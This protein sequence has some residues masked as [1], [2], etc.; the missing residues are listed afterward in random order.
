[1]NF[2][3]WTI[4]FRFKGILNLAAGPP[5]F[6]STEFR[7]GTLFDLSA[8]GPQPYPNFLFSLYDFIGNKTP[9]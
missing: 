8:P 3:F 6:R 9:L 1:M 2:K 7:N 4:F 5:D